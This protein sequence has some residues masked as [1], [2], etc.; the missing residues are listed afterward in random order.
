[1][2]T[3]ETVDT[4]VVPGPQ[5]V[6]ETPLPAPATDG[7]AVVPAPGPM[8]TETIES[9]PP[10]SPGPGPVAPTEVPSVPPSAAVARVPTADAP[11]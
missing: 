5:P 1:M 4:P 6:S 3:P 7:A 10:A 2:T 8:F 9:G 11:L